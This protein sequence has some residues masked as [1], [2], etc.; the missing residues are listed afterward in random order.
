[1][2]ASGLN[3]FWD[4]QVIPRGHYSP[5]SVGNTYALVRPEPSQK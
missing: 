2:T 4:S 3:A 5:C 1:M